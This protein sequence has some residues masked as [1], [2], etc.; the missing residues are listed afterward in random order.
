LGGIESVVY[1]LTIGVAI[2]AAYKVLNVLFKA[3]KEEEN[4][5]PPSPEMSKTDW[6]QTIGAAVLALVV[7][8]TIHWAYRLVR[9]GVAYGLEMFFNPSG[10]FLLA[11]VN[12]FLL[13]LLLA[14]N[15]SESY[16]E[17]PPTRRMLFTINLFLFLHL[18]V[19]WRALFG[20]VH[21]IRLLIVTSC[22]VLV[23]SLVLGRVVLK[24]DQDAATAV[25]VTIGVV[26]FS[27]ILAIIVHRGG[28]FTT[29]AMMLVLI[30]SLEAG[31]IMGYNSEI[32]QRYIRS[33]PPT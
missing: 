9:S 8:T 28:S 26:F 13:F 2:F 25:L 23:T 4:T 10:W 22:V 33:R 32:F 6:Y 18:F 17:D 29:K 27:L 31:T 15:T 14:R 21:L 1:V 30:F 3:K 5:T 12:S 16:I 20:M 11:L 24:D 7:M 19:I